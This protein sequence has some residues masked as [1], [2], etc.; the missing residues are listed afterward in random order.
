M[1]PAAATTATSV[2]PIALVD[3]DCR[4][5][6]AMLAAVAEAV[7]IASQR[8]FADP[9]WGY[10]CASSITVRPSLAAVLPTE[11]AALLL[12]TP[13]APGALGYHDES[14]SIKVF[15]LIDDIANLGV[16]LS[17]EI[18]ERDADENCQ[19]CIIGPDGK[20]RLAEPGDPVEDVR[21][22]YDVTVQSGAK[23]RV[24]DFVGKDYF[25]GAEPGKAGHFDFC[26][27]VKR[28]G[29]VLAGGYQTMYSRGKYTQVT[30]GRKRHYREALDALVANG[31]H[32][33]RT[34]RAMVSVPR[35][36]DRHGQLVEGTW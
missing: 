34:A 8:D 24:S 32:Q 26:G 11:R 6:P 15:P 9:K 20:I 18:F 10:R 31:A 35:I 28:P 36:V 2:Q 25:A 33:H 23:I 1:P 29:Q 21:F 14:R 22:G 27:H 4:L 3:V 5:D 7:S 19:T 12:R 17:H 13:D 16:T 30:R